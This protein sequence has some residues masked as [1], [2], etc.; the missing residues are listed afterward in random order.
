[1]EAESDDAA[2]LV[3]VAAGICDP[4]NCR[5]SHPSFPLADLQIKARLKPETIRYLYDQIELLH[6]QT[7]PIIPLATD[8]ELFL[9]GASLQDGER[10]GVIEAESLSSANRIRRLATALLDAMRL[11]E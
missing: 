7:C 2:M 9:L 11:S 6:I 4:N 8:E 5:D 1:M 10:L 3:L